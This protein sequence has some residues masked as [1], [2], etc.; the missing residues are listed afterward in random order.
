MPAKNRV[1]LGAFCRGSDHQ[2]VRMVSRMCGV[3][4]QHGSFGKVRLPTAR[5]SYAVAFVMSMA[6]QA[7]CW[8]A[9][10]CASIGQMPQWERFDKKGSCR[11]RSESRGSVWSVR[12]IYRS[13]SPTHN[14]VKSEVDFP[15]VTR[16]RWPFESSQRKN[17]STG[18]LP[19]RSCNSNLMMC[20]AILWTDS[21]GLDSQS[22]TSS[23][24]TRT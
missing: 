4:E 18:E 12:R 16:V 23:G 14:R 6:Q 5:A 7:K 20:R 24:R 1:Y 19:R 17:G 15:D 9:Y 10:R 22:S 3:W 11:N 2:R 8:G 21:G 13:A